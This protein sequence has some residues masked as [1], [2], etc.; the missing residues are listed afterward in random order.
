M[1]H[2]LRIGIALG[3]GGARGAAHIGVLQ[4]LES[5]GIGIDTI[6]GTSAGAVIG[7][8]YAATLNSDWVRQHYLD[9]LN[10]DT[11]RAMGTHHLRRDTPE[12]DSF[13]QQIGRFVKDHLV[14]SLAVHRH[15]IVD[16][17]KLTQGI[18][19]LLPVSSFN[20]LKIPLTITSTDLNSGKEI[21]T[22]S[23]DL[24]EAVVESSS[25]PGFIKPLEEK[26]RLIVDGA[27]AAP[28][29]VKAL[30]TYKNDV[31]IAVDIARRKMKPLQEFSLLEL[32][33]RVGQVTGVKLA[34]ELASQ[35]DVLIQPDVGEAHWSEF[36]RSEA[37]IIAGQEGAKAAIPKI[38]KLLNERSGLRYRLR[39]SLGFI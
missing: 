7:A 4:T 10:S 28:V 19:Y 29:P 38:N 17:E 30:L 5:Q 37:F 15:G 34:D 16:R 25:I 23:G 8:M 21:V 33:S 11:F 1:S 36:S 32:M 12:K 2:K 14:I 3:G 24:V 13:F 27:V 18:R 22:S 9:Y 6:A 35:A 31:C 20:E 26:N 39:K